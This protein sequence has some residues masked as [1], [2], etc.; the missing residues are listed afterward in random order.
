MVLSNVAEEVAVAVVVQGLVQDKDTSLLHP[1]CQYRLKRVF[2][3]ADQDLAV[4]VWPE[5]HVPA[6]PNS[7]AT[8]NPNSVW[9]AHH[10]TG[11]RALGTVAAVLLRRRQTAIA[12]E[13][14]IR[15]RILPLQRLCQAWLGSHQLRH[16][17]DRSWHLRRQCVSQ[18]SRH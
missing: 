15:I 6:K 2:L 5:N 8:T 13:L 14:R 18:A 12:K 16:L 10:T 3:C 4:A 1:T 7:K 11:A 17:L 9:S